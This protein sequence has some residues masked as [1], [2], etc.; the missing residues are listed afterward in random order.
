MKLDRKILNV[1][2]LSWGYAVAFSIQ[3]WFHQVSDS[4]DTWEGE[5]RRI[6]FDIAFIICIIIAPSYVT[7]SGT[8][9][10]ILTSYI[11]HV[12][13]I[14][15]VVGPLRCNQKL[16]YSGSAA[17]GL[18][19]ALAIVA[20]GRCLTENSTSRTIHRHAWIFWLSYQI[21]LLSRNILASK[22]LLMGIYEILGLTIIQ[23]I[24]VN[25][26]L[27]VIVSIT[28]GLALREPS[29]EYSSGGLECIPNGKV[30][31]PQEPS[32]GPFFTAWKPLK[33][34]FALIV[35]SKMLLLS[36][37]LGY[38]GLMKAFQ[39][40]RYID[41]ETDEKA[42][43]YTVPIGEIFGALFSAFWF[44][45]KNG[46]SAMIVFIGLVMLATSYSFSTINVLHKE[47]SFW[48]N[49]EELSQGKLNYYRA[50][51]LLERFSFGFGDACFHTQIY[52]LLGALFSKN[53]APAFALAGLYYWVGYSCGYNYVTKWQ[54]H[55][56]VKF[57]LA[58]G[59]LAAISVALVEILYANRGSD[60]ETENEFL[61]SKE[62]SGKFS[63]EIPP[64]IKMLYAGFNN[65][66]KLEEIPRDIPI[67]V[68]VPE[69]E[70]LE[71]L[72]EK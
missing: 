5:K 48:R 30:I 23:P 21:F 8:S 65:K 41:L 61:K 71:I 22:P 16:N 9:V 19:A 67:S 7:L 29:R 34:F 6:I 2:L 44:C 54:L 46:D 63:K 55:S 12:F 66:E 45:N 20:Q 64:E 24:T 3:T 62:T 50:M 26:A 43:F 72:S 70:I 51:T 39:F 17:L 28:S 13:Y 38:A 35:S 25:F 33:D 52:S 42:D 40:D 1:I 11:C 68:D 14:S 10:S 27:I 53:S 47:D 56:Q 18:G 58:T 59:I 37:M 4:N 69:V 36:I 57:F 49:P 15:S 32:V 60:H 31:E